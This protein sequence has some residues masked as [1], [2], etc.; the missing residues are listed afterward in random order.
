MEPIPSIDERD[1]NGGKPASQAV[2]ADAAAVPAG[3]ATAAE[4]AATQRLPALGSAGA[5]AATTQ[6]MPALGAPPAAPAPAAAHPAPPAPPARP[7]AAVTPSLT[8]AGRERCPVCASPIAPDQRYCVECGQRLAG[9]RPTLMNDP[10]LAG[11]GT[12]GPPPRKSRFDW[13]PNAIFLAGLIALLLALGV[14]V[15][16]GHYAASPS[17][18]K[19]AA[20][21]I[22]VS[23]LGATGTTGTAAETPSSSSGGSGSKG[24]GG[25]S[26]GGGSASGNGGAGH[27]SAAGSKPANP[28]VHLG[29]KGHGQGYQ[30]GEFTGHFFGNE[31]EENAGEEEPEGS[32]SAGKKKH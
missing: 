20:T 2:D 9:A 8:A 1:A 21:P 29:Q 23:G 15:L 27:P 17:S 11:T 28:T 14:G 22:V 6:V 3:G 32:S 12:P 5:P 13:G 26:T 24:G 16:I 25:K 18:N 30:H 10:A 4:E 7:P 19:H 31:N